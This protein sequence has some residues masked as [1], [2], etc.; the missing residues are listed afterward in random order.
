[1]VV[2]PTSVRELLARLASRVVRARLLTMAV[3]SEVKHT[4]RARRPLRRRSAGTR[5]GVFALLYLATLPR[6]SAEALC[7]CREFD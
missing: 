5:Q 3:S 7:T 2:V 6:D 4:V 1:M